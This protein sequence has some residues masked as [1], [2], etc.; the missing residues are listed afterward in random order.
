[1]NVTGQSVVTPRSKTMTGSPLA[2]A[3]RR[4]GSA[5][6]WCSARRSSRRSL[7][8][9]LASMSEICLS[10]FASA[11]T[12]V[13]FAD[14]LGAS[15]LGLH[16]DQADL[17]PRVVDRGVGEAQ[18][19]ARP[20]WTWISVD[21]LRVDHLLPRLGRGRPRA[22]PSAG[23]AACRSRPARRTSTARRCST[24]SLS[25]AAGRRLAAAALCAARAVVLVRKRPRWRSR[26]A[27]R[28]G[29][30]SLLQVIRFLLCCCA[31]L[32]SRAPEPVRGKAPRRR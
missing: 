24:S 13:N 2:R 27:G 20:S 28:K 7:A 12:T 10:S 15:H 6:R 21:H 18:V 19:P 9:E 22:S 31:S 29:P 23:R 3:P 8:A 26:P 16:G 4:P 5:S 14:L 30:A 25:V 1:M 17:T 11:S 32:S